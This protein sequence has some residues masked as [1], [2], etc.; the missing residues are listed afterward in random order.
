MAEKIL[1]IAGLVCRNDVSSNWKIKNP[2]LKRGEQG[3]ELDTGLTKIGD[4]V[5]AW[6]E[7]DYTG[8]TTLTADDI[9]ELFENA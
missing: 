7:L 3:L 6:K 1:N 9:D 2:I 4:G 8:V 5:T